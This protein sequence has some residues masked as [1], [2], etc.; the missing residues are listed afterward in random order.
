MKPILSFAEAGEP[1]LD[2]GIDKFSDNLVDFRPIVA[3]GGCPSIG[4]PSRQGA[5]TSH[6]RSGTSRF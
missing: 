1:G 4:T 3:K 2:A 6:N 5:Q